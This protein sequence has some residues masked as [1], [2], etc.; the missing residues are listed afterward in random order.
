MK[1]VISL[2]VIA[3]MCM[4]LC[5][6]EAN[7]SSPVVISKNDGSFD[8]NLSKS[9]TE[10]IK[11]TENIQCSDSFSSTDGSLEFT[12]NIEQALSTSAMPVVEVVPHKFLPEDVKRVANVLFEG[13]IFYEREPSKNPSYS[14]EQLQKTIARWSKYTNSTAMAELIMDRSN[15]LI[16]DRID[17]LKG[18]IDQYTEKLDTAPVD[19]PHTL[20]DW[21]F[22]KDS[23]YNNLEA[24]FF[25][26]STS[27]EL[28][29]IYSTV[30]AGNIEYIFTASTHDSADYKLNTIDVTLSSGVG[31]AEIDLMIYRAMLCRT[32][33]PTDD[34]VLSISKKAQNMLN[35]MELGDWV[36]TNAYVETNDFEDITEHVVVVE[37]TP[38][39]NG[40]AAIYGQNTPGATAA[41]T[42]NAYYPV[43]RAI[44]GFSANGTLVHFR[45]Q[46][47]VDVKEVK[48]PNV[49]TLS[50]EKLLETAKSNLIL[51]DAHAG[52]G[53][54]ADMVY[55][56]EEASNEDLICKIE[57][58]SFTYG[59]AR[60]DVANSN[61]NYYYVPTIVFKGNADYYGK[62]T[63][64]LY[65]SSSDY[66]ASDLNLLWINAI[67][68]SIILQ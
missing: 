8:T 22:K 50:F 31:P 65:I 7:P 37:A 1:K 35:L 55:M 61:C 33:E 51:R 43:S 53:V 34:Q 4:Q 45:M 42:Y 16:V 10:G 64:N 24:E 66:K 25:G 32:L 11:A 2:L 39:F 18:Y 44:F 12:V 48:N 6:C 9:A 30:E 49:A 5:A 47:P 36:V 20:C 62:D 28:D 17:L 57:I 60:I 52:Y 14:K 40:V 46:S 23:H 68:G 67:D 27:D 56:Y 58:N 15:E 29:V 21:K 38:A 19:N 63:G 13:A 54:P 59:L 26:G 41:D 3:L